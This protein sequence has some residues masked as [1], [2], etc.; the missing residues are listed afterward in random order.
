M[1]KNAPLL[2]DIGQ[3]LSVMIGLVTIASW[4][5]KNRP[6]KAARGTFGFNSQTKSLEYW[7]GS[8]WWNAPLS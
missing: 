1:G 2:L 4:N 6:K 3:G 5:T 7:D 8:F